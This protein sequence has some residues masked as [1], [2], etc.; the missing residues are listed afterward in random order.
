MEALKVIPL[1]AAEATYRLNPELLTRTKGNGR[2]IA[3]AKFRE[4]ADKLESGELDCA[5]VQWSD[6]HGLLVEDSDGKQY[7]LT[8][9]TGPQDAQPISGL[10]FVTRTAWAEDGSGTVQ[11]VALTI[12]EEG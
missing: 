7:D 3:V 4:L 11:L 6:T 1:P 9:V 10:E 5:R 8:K 2:A 12:E